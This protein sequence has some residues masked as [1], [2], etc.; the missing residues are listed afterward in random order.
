M[1]LDEEASPQARGRFRSRDPLPAPAAA[2]Q[3]DCRGAFVRPVVLP[4]LHR[5][6]RPAARGHASRHPHVAGAQPR[7]PGLPVPAPQFEDA[8]SL[9]LVCPGRRAAD[10]LGLRPGDRSGHALRTVDLRGSRVPRR[11]S[12]AHRRG[13]GHDPD[14]AAA[15]GDA[16]LDGLA[17]ADPRHA[18][19]ALCVFRA[20]FPR[21]LHPPGRHVERDRQSPL[22]HQPGHLRHRAGRGRDLCVPLRA[23]R[24]AGHAHR[25]RADVHR[26]RVLRRGQ[27]C[28]RP[29]EG[30]DLRLGPVRHDL[31]LLDRQHGD[32]RLA[33]HPG[34]DP[35]GLSAAFCGRR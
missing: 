26:P 2:G 3:L 33:D 22:S 29:G 21:H 9:V 7:L 28:R 25:P 34:D 15:G 19:H 31:R 35:A 14:R 18:V 16:P 17:A 1:K 6:L 5:R 8:A 10:R 23:V 30:L 12:A 11:Q 24:R 4:L 13:D 20:A 27:L 32:G